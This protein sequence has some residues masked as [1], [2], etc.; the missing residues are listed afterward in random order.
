MSLICVYTL[1]VIRIIDAEAVP[2]LRRCSL[3]GHAD[4]KTHNMLFTRAPIATDIF[5]DV[6]TDRGFSVAHVA[7]EQIV[8]VKF[9]MQTGAIE[10]RVDLLHHFR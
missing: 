8:P 3:A 10:S 6:L 5:I 7:E 2:L 9:N 4:L 1:Q